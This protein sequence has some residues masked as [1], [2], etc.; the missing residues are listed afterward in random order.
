MSR[1]TRAGGAVRGPASALTSFLANLGVQPSYRSTTWENQSSLVD[2]NTPDANGIAVSSRTDSA[3]VATDSF[4]VAESDRVD[5][6]ISVQEEDSLSIGLKRDRRTDSSTEYHSKRLRTA[7]IDSDD[8][9]ADDGA[10]AVASNTHNQRRNNNVSSST[11][12]EPGPLKSIGEFMDCGECGKKFTVTAYTKEHPSTS[13]TYLCVQCCY[14]LDIDPF[15]KIK[16]VSAK[17]VTKKQE[18]AKIIHYEE[19]KGVQTLGDM[20]IK[21]IGQY[22]EDVDQLR[23]IGAIN[24]DK[25][26]KIICKSRRLTPETASLFYSVDRHSLEMWDCTNLTPASFMALANLC[27]NLQYIRL[28]LVGQMSTEVISHWSKMLKKLKRLE[29]YGP[30]LVRKEGWIE[31]VKAIGKQLEGFLVTQSPRIDEE[32]VGELVKCCPTLREVRLSEV[33]LNSSMIR[34]LH[35][36]SNLTSLDLSSPAESLS[37]DTIIELLKKIGATL[38]TLVLADNSSLTDQVLPV[39]AETCPNLR[40]LSLRNLVELT[41]DGVADFFKTLKSNRHVG[42]SWIDLEKGHDLKDAA[43]R[44][45]IE[46]SGEAVEWLSLLGWRE[47]TLETLNMLS[48]CKKLKH[49]DVG[50]CRTVNNFWVK[51]ILDECECIE[52]IRVWGCNELSNGIPRKRGVRVI[53]IETHSI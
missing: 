39:I 1:R 18:R 6:V 36:L 3:N 53:G 28:D 4:I 32:T 8:L 12:V 51:A 48:G 52:E 34:M 42:F 24:M 22:I 9:D 46:H 29:L 7:S 40:R 25:V 35:P 5:Q 13:Q 33:I 11:A 23:D 10:L 19:K 45:L 49:L 50:W 21:L 37:D 27:P 17:K 41:D 20:C 15:A 16:K 44:A 47:I 30:F 31:F 14:A 43:L 2:N 26:C 38:E